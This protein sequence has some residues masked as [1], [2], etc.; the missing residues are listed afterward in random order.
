MP[1]I[2]VNGN[3][4]FYRRMGSGRSTLVFIHGLLMD[5]MSSW[6]FAVANAAAQHADTLCYDLRGHGL[7]ERPA[8][9]YTVADGVSDLLGLLDAL[10]IDEPVHLF[11]NSY[12]GVVAVAFAI[13]HPERVADMV[14]IEPH[15]GAEGLSEDELGRLSAG[16]DE[17]LTGLFRDDVKGWL[18]T[19]GGRRMNR[20]VASWKD[21]LTETSLIEDLRQTKTFSDEALSSIA[22]R[23]LLVFG[24][25]SDIFERARVLAERIPDSE[26]QVWG[27]LDH[28]VLREAPGRVRQLVLDWIRSAEAAPVNSQT[29]A[30]H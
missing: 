14:L 17:A 6:W 12:G 28:L 8:T 30:G 21:F 16:L 11:G 1:K 15:V 20:L 3:E 7:S 25:E 18:E 22:C 23:V 13:A 5:N 29:L 10:G 2:R 26:L 9:G 27:D 24:E 4:L 19:K